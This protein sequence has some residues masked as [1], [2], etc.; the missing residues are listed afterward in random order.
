[1]KA[2]IVDDD[3]VLADV[4]A[5]TLRREGYGIVLAHDG[6]TALQRFAEEMPDLVVLD[7]NM[8]RLDGFAVCRR[9]RQMADT[10]IILL[11]VRGEEDDIVRGL[12]LGA[13][14]YMTKPFSPRQLVA[15]AQAVLRRSRAGRSTATAGIQRVGNLALDPSRREIQALH[16]D[17]ADTATGDPVSL[18][19][20]ETRLLSYLMLNAGHVL[21][22]DAI[23]DHVWGVDGGDREMLRQLVRRLRGK[24]KELS[25]GIDQLLGVPTIE[26]IPGVGYGL[27]RE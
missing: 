10:P 12:G 6:E 13:D 25:D 11:T 2:L 26:T 14:D 19:A 23:I 22:A 15:R 1:M 5:F 27:T 18:T 16:G 9:I 7:V 20:L 3:R 24:L 17:D 21:M 8:P 4:L